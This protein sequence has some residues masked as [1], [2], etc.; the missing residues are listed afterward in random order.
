MQ[1]SSIF[2]QS[3]LTPTTM[4]SLL[5]HLSQCLSPSL[6]IYV[7]KHSL[8]L[9]IRSQSLFFP[10]CDLN[11]CLLLILNLSIS[12]SLSQ[13]TFSISLSQYTFSNYIFFLIYAHNF[14]L[15]LNILSQSLSLSLSLSQYTFSNTHSFSIYALN[16]SFSYTFTIFLSLS[17]FAFSISV[18]QY[19][20]LI[21]VSFY[22]LCQI[23]FL[24]I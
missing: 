13:H 2:Q 20:F 22:V 9:N 11:L 3:T 24:N 15:I 12:L 4:G 17:D 1:I 10:L 7:L 8:F 23:I 19:K 5:V 6:S 16:L 18:S 14:C 21:S